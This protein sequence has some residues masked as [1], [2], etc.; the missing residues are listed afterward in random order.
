MDDGFGERPSGQCAT[1]HKAALLPT[2]DRHGALGDST[3]GGG[4]GAAYGFT[5]LQDG[6]RAVTAPGTAAYKVDGEPTQS[7]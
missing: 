3:T 6:E 1:G 2:N 7:V 4:N 5:G